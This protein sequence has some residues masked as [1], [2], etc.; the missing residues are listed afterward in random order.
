MMLLSRFWYV[1]LSLVMAGALYVSFLAVGQY[2][3][4]VHDKNLLEDLWN[5]NRAPW[6][7][8]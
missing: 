7:V 3:R 8:W 5:S 1:L 4:L 6:K 2:N